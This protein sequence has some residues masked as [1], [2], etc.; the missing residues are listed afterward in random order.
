VCADYHGV[1]QD[2]NDVGT[3]SRWVE[4][5]IKLLDNVVSGKTIIVGAAVGA[6]VMLLVGMKRP[7]LVAGMVGVSC[8]PDFTEELL[9]RH[10]SEEDKN[11]IMT[12][13]RHEITWGENKYQIT[14]DLIVDGRENLVLQGGPRSLPITCPLR[15]IHG[16]DDEEV[17]L[18]TALRILEAVETDDVDVTVLKGMHHFI[19]DQKEFLTLRRQLDSVLKAAELYEFDLRSPGSG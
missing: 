14:K 18:A 8:D 16:T 11:A 13:G 1:S 12:K 15:L 7:D 19:D 4:D 17:P 9:W 5:T 2:Q 3:I 6:W 10:L